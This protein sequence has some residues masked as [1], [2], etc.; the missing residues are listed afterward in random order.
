MTCS[1]FKVTLTEW[2]AV[3]GYP[4]REMTIVITDTDSDDIGTP[5]QS[6][7]IINSRPLFT[8]SYLSLIQ[9][10]NN[11]GH[12]D[13]EFKDTSSMKLGTEY[14]SIERCNNGNDSV[15]GADYVNNLLTYEFI[16]RGLCH[17]FTARITCH[18]REMK[19]DGKCNG[20]DEEC[21]ACN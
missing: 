19:T 9:Y 18:E 8:S 14:L 11:D 20:R 21:A 12:I 15:N 17:G 10:D 16:G 4:G 6:Q 13:Y 2:S 7:L 3:Y 5:G 1:V